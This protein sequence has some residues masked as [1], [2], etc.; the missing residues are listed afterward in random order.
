[1]VRFIIYQAASWNINLKKPLIV[2]INT[3][4][5]LKTCWPIID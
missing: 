1:M 4:K 2:R 3:K 5:D